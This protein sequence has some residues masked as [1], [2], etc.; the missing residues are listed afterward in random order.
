MLPRKYK[1]L[2][3]TFDNLS[4]CFR[5]IGY[6]P[7][8]PSLRIRYWCVRGCYWRWTQCAAAPFARSLLFYSCLSLIGELLLR[9]HCRPISIKV[10]SYDAECHVLYNANSYKY[11]LKNCQEAVQT[12]VT[13]MSLLKNMWK[14]KALEKVRGLIRFSN[15]KVSKSVICVS[16]NGFSDLFFS[17]MINCTWSQPSAFVR[18]TST[19]TSVLWSLLETACRELQNYETLFKCWRKIGAFASEVMFVINHGHH[20]QCTL[21]VLQ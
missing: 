4:R 21:F 5:W 10:S 14:G 18:S 9:L 2:R 6:V 1:H 19:S 17:V 12:W 8:S 16:I 15:D 11:C 13:I 7:V 20:L 3:I